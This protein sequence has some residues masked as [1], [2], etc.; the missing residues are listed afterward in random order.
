MEKSKNIVVVG[1]GL[2][3]LAGACYLAQAGNTVSVYEKNN[4]IGGRLRVLKK[5]GFQFDMGPSW[6][7]MPDVFEKFYRDFNHTTSDFYQ[8]D[9]LDPGYKVFFKDG[10][11]ISISAHMDRI[12]EVFEKEEPGSSQY[13]KRF[14]K[15]A[16]KNYDIAINDLV[17]KPG[18]S[19]FE[20]VRLKTVV[21]VNQFFSTIAKDVRKYIKSEKLRE[22]L[23]FPVLF[24][25]AKASNTPSFYSFMNFADFG[26]GTWHPKGGMYQIVNAFVAIAKELGVEFHTQSNVSEI[27]VENNQ[28][29]GC[30][31]ND[32]LIEADL[33]LSGADYH[34]T[35]QLLDKNLRQYS[36]SY[37]DKKTFAPSSL[38]FYVGFDC[39]IEGV[40]HHNLFFDTDFE[41]H[42]SS[43]YDHAEWPKDPLFYANFPSKTD[44][45]FAPE[46]KDGGFFLIPIA[47][48]LKDLGDN[49]DYYFD[50]I[51]NRLEFQTKQKIRDK[52]LFREVFSLKDFVKDY[53]SY[54]GNAY[55]MA[56]TLMQTAVLRPNLASSKV[57]NLYFTGQ[58]TVPGPGLPPA[59]I[60]GKVVSDLILSKN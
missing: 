26:L 59:I 8:L 57:K 47:P 2:S 4:Q 24:L 14:I 20:L 5:D 18:E 35:E 25:G 42:A 41:T 1:S 51:I 34:H 37:W 49:Y 15:R 33:V 10:D 48:G 11:S 12:Y 43:I 46:G 28:V 36:E 23:E 19:I 60:S 21:N 38:L 32:K 17:Y 3:A 27:L 39:K 45:E 40:E 30:V 29:K 22:I 16:E 44:E 9:R 52:V 31:I 50:M 56:N 55:G 58:L 54:K 53:N 7:W 6:Y 13:L